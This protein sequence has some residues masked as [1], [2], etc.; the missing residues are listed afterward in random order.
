MKTLLAAL[1]LAG[2]A[3]CGT[4]HP[5]AE[6]QPVVAASQP[7]ST[8]T[9]T[10]CTDPQPDPSYVCAQAC[11]PPIARPTPPP[12]RY[13]W[14]PP[15]HV[16]EGK[17]YPCPICLPAG[18]RIAAPGGD[19]AVEDVRAGMIIWTRDAAGQRVAA[20]VRR[21][22]NAPVT[23][24]TL[25]ELTLADGRVVAASAGHPAPG[26]RPIGALAT[27]DRLDGAAIVRVRTVPYRGERTY[28]LLPDGPTGTYW[29][30]GVLLGSTLTASSPAS[31]AD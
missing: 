20:P 7:A 29:A 31:P 26:G 1:A 12:P 9:V 14:A 3:A 11:G 19:R 4:S 28:D 30:D 18:T 21:V 8:T 23:G 24:H 22:G 13:V 5:P 17:V 15:E 6:S 16:R 10:L 2:A 27:G 25:V